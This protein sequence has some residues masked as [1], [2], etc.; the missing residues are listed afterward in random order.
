MTTY[1][2]ELRDNWRPLLA[3][4]FGMGTGYAALALYTP[5]VI[6]P[7]LIAEFGWSK[8][9]FAALGSISLA[10]ALCIPF[11]GRLAD[12]IG[13]K[14]TALIGMITLPLSFVAY[15]LMTGPMW[16]YVAIYLFQSIFCITMTS[17]V[18]SRVAVQYIEKARGLALAIVAIGPT[19][20]GVAAGPVLNAYIENNGWR[21]TY[22]LLTVFS[23]VCAVITFFL[24]PPER[25]A[26]EAPP[27]RRRA[28]EDYPE[29]L[30]SRLFWI[31]VAS[32]LL[33]NL[34]QVLALSQLKLL[35]MDNGISGTKVGALLSAF[36]L[37]VLAGRFISG[38]ALDRFPAHWVGMLSMGLPSIG[39]I[40]LAS[41][42]D[43]Y[44]VLMA[45]VV[46]LG[47]SYGAEGDIIAYI[48]AGRF[49]VGLYGSIM[50]LMSMA[51]SISASAGAL[52]LSFLLSQ[53]GN[54]N[55][56]LLIC[57]GGAIVGSLML[58]LVRQPREISA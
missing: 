26:G 58:L 12:V 55:L 42:M 41:S 18:Y 30:R 44:G 27:P 54:F 6:A 48:I 32:M 23:V 5:S 15:S 57:A 36:P 21:A 25:R 56:F 50:G 9:A 11:A 14:L 38:G 3:A 43:S 52:L 29:I 45:S 53:T 33:C 35:L 17:T 39:L 19:I 46:M 28:R 1:L 37:G 7:H 40:L 4:T 16:Q 20:T 51:I 22:H 13:V 8:S 47:F 2:G 24:L 34:S 31:L 10:V 49:G